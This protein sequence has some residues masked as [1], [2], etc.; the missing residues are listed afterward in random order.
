MYF[1]SPTYGKLSRR[2]LKQHISLFM[3]L[4]QSAQYRLIIGVDSQ[5]NATHTFDFVTAV[6]IQRLGKGGIYFWKREVLQKKIGLKERMYT[7]AIMSLQSAE[8]IIKLFK[9]NGIA[10]YDIEIHVD[11]GNNGKTKDLISEIVGMVRS[12]GYTVK[13]KPDAFGASN[14][15]DRHV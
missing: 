7:E 11:I 13:I 6:I 2:A 10:K 3:K 9:G 4:D 5:R 14:V 15:A 12:S 8:D 1:V